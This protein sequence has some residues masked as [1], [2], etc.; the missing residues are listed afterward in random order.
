MFKGRLLAA[1]LF[2][3][4]PQRTKEVFLS[5]CFTSQN[6]SKGLHPGQYKLLKTI[7]VS[8]QK[9]DSV[10]ILALDLTLLYFKQYGLLLW[11][12]QQ[13]NQPEIPQ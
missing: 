5:V 7:F 6:Y 12:C 9:F 2:C 10:M 4:V 13:N 1:L 11:A 3:E 8:H